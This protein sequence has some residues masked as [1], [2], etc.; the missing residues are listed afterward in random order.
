MRNL[1]AA[2]LVGL[3][4]VTGC[5]ALKAATGTTT[6]GQLFCA[7]AS[8]NGGAVTV[9]LVSAVSPGVAVLAMDATR[10]FVVAACAAA[11]GVPVSPPV[12]PAAAPTVAIVPPP[13]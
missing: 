4:A 7:L 5:A 8:G 13:A 11:H 1:I 6:N 12:N 9:A 3:T 10:D 2:C